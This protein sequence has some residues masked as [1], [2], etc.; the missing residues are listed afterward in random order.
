MGHVVP[1]VA[2]PEE[3]SERG[4]LQPPE[5]FENNKH[6]VPM[7]AEPEQPSEVAICEPSHHHM[8]NGISAVEETRV[9]PLCTVGRHFVESV[10]PKQGV[11]A[12]DANLGAV[13]RA[14]RR[15]IGNVYS[16]I[17]TRRT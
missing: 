8:A 2:E 10:A 17:L 4:E 9:E 11:F 14:S 3:P 5:Q 6:V 15:K 1:M 13:E 12:N 7:V 16:Q